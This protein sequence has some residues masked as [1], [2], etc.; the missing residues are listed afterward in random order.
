MQVYFNA[1]GTINR[2]PVTD[3]VFFKNSG[4]NNYIYLYG[5]PDG[6]TVTVS[7]KR[8]DGKR[9]GPYQASYGNDPDETYCVI[10]RVP[11]S[12]LK[13][14][15]ELEIFILASHEETIEGEVETVSSAYASITVKVFDNDAIVTP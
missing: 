13:V 15:G 12:P 6:Q 1:N 11:A 7:Y 4:N 8:E 3:T 10:I 9:V 14:A 2:I 5:I